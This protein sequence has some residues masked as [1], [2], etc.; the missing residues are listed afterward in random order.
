MR[1]HNDTVR[2]LPD[3]PEPAHDL[4]DVIEKAR[5]GFITFRAAALDGAA[6]LDFDRADIV[7][8]IEGLTATDFY[9]S[10]DAEIATWV[11]CRQDVYMPT[12]CGA[13]IYLKFQLWPGKRLH[14]VSFK[15]KK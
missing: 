4:A 15:R 6:E 13:K 12:Y 5:V 8:C 9:K 10:M 2:V 11:G 1:Y 7:A 14:I 3:H